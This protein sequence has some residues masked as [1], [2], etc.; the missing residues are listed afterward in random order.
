[1]EDPEVVNAR[2]KLAAKFG[3]KA[4]I[5]GKGSMRRKQKVVHKSNSVDD[6]KL[7]S[8]LRKLGVQPLPAI[9]E[10]NFF[11]DDNTILNFVNPGVQ[12]NIK[13]NFF[14]VSGPSESKGIKD[15]M[16]GILSQ[17]GPKNMDFIKEILQGAKQESAEE[18]PDLVGEQNFE[19]IANQE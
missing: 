16:P 18:V 17:L 3:D 1:M 6:K 7:Q 12:A 13:D 19:D 2:A 4:R 8:S 14:I 9:E 5:G 10:V 11:R 15:L